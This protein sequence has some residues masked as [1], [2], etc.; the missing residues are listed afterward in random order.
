MYFSIDILPLH[1]LKTLTEMFCKIQQI[2]VKRIKLPIEKMI[3]PP[4][5]GTN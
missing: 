2:L 5:Q 4:T 1:L 3:L